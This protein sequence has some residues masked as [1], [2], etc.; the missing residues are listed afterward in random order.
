[1]LTRRWCS[2]LKT[3]FWNKRSKAPYLHVYIKRKFYITQHDP[4]QWTW[5]IIDMD[6]DT[7]LI[8][9]FAFGWG[10]GPGI[11]VALNTTLWITNRLLCFCNFC[12]VPVIS[13]LQQTHVCNH[14]NDSHWVIIDPVPLP[15]HKYL[16]YIQYSLYMYPTRWINLVGWNLPKS[17]DQWANRNRCS[18]KNFTTSI[19][20]PIT[21]K[22]IWSEE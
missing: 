16:G 11:T 7:I 15:K 4:L 8:F 14:S 6:M 2:C 17:P 10:K 1:M 20:I 19:I 12:A 3:C 9:S 21:G 18:V 13:H 5:H 22:H